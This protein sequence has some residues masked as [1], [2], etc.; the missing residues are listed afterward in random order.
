[1]RFFLIN[2]WL[3]LLLSCGQTTAQLLFNNIEHFN[4]RNGLSSNEVKA[5]VQDQDGFLWIATPE[6]LNRYDGERFVQFTHT[7]D[8]NSII[9]DQLSSIIVLPDNQLAIGTADGLTIMDTHKRTFRNIFFARS[10]DLKLLD[11]NVYDLKLDQKG[12]LWVLTFSGLHILDKSFKVI[13]SYYTPKEAYEKNRIAL[14]HNLYEVEG[15]KFIIKNIQTYQINWV[16]FSKKKLVPAVQ[17]FPHLSFLNEL[18]TCKQAPDRTLWV[19]LRNTNVVY[20][21]FPDTRK[22]ESFQINIK[23]SE[24]ANDR[25]A[26]IYPLDNNTAII[27]KQEGKPILLNLATNQLKDLSNKPVWTASMSGNRIP[28]YLK[29][30][31]GSLWICHFDGLYLISKSKQAIITYPNIN[32]AI[33]SLSWSVASAPT[34]QRMSPDK[35]FVGTYGNGWFMSD[36]SKDDMERFFFGSKQ[37]PEIAVGVSTRLHSKDTLWLAT[38]YGLWWFKPSTYQFGRIRNS[39]K[40]TAL[41]SSLVNYQYIDS[42]GLIWMG[43]ANGNGTIIYDP[44]TNRFK[45][46]SQKTKPAFPLRMAYSITEDYEGNMW[47]GTPAGGGLIK[48]DRKKDTFSIIKVGEKKG[49]DSDAISFMTADKKGN[50]YLA[51]RVGVFIY[52]LRKDT[53]TLYDKFDGLLSNDVEHLLLDKNDILWIGSPQGLNYLNLKTNVIQHLTTANG[54]AN[55]NIGAILPFNTA[56]DTLFIGSDNSF[57]LL[58]LDNFNIKRSAPKPFI[59]GIKINNVDVPFNSNEPLTVNYQQ[60]DVTFEYVGLN[61]NN[62]SQNRYKYIL[63]GADNTWK[64]AQNNKYASYTNLPAGS[65]TFKVTAMSDGLNWSRDVATFTL[66]ITPP[67]WKTLWFR[68]IFLLIVSGSL[69]YIYRRQIKDIEVREAEKTEIQKQINELKL[70]ALRSQLNPHFIFNVLNSIQSFILENNPVEASR[71]LSKFAKLVRLV[72]DNS[73]SQF[74]SLNKEVELLTYF[75]QMESLRFSNSFQYNIE[76]DDAIEPTEI[77][78]PS[79]MIQPHVE[80]AIWHGLMTGRREGHQGKIWIRFKKDTKETL[81]CEIEDNGIGRKAAGNI[82]QAHKEHVSKGTSLIKNRLELMKLEENYT[83]NIQTIDLENEQGEGIG[84]RVVM[85]LPVKEVDI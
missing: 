80:N 20:K 24:L 76:V 16:D 18:N 61:F 28:T 41:D 70:T 46:Y 73:G 71:Y 3:T 14:G 79:M 68:V 49:F 55:N 60:N 25:L 54:L 78:I 77:Q 69:Y 32:K 57:S 74:V 39:T 72:L 27:E 12:N 40:P 29:D 62:G 63:D 38:Q 81:I 82:Q 26:T 8:T 67:W 52:D 58:A 51:T 42:K 2:I 17:K 30:K 83:L 64:D 56:G 13:Q 21:Y 75:V 85:V 33:N 65:Y 43:V 34:F 11:N 44:K 4:S 36:L 5:I 31:D 35:I 15:N 45:Q 23:P 6:G 53:F 7:K 22:V 9:S 37:H 84:T 66:I 1:M 19:L 50:L 10:T 47:M 59:T 48:W